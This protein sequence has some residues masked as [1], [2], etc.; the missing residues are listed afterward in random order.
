MTASHFNGSH[1]LLALVLGGCS[2]GAGGGSTGSPTASGT[3]EPT[4]AATGGAS[5]ADS[6]GGPTGDAPGSAST[7]EPTGE[8][9]ATTTSASG[10]GTTGEE[11]GMEPPVDTGPDPGDGFKPD[12]MPTGWK[13]ADKGGIDDPGGQ[14]PDGLGGVPKKLPQTG[15]A[16]CVK[17]TAGCTTE[18]AACPLYITINTNGAFFTRADDPATYGDFI[19]VELYVESDGDEIKHKLAELPRVIDHDYAGLDRDRV[20]AIGWSAGAGAVFRGL[21]HQSKK[22]DFSE[23]GTTSDIYAAVI[24]LGGCGCARDYVQL[25]GN[26]HV[27][28]FNGQNDPFNG[29]DACE[30]G[31]RERAAVNACSDLDATWQPLPADHPYVKNGDGSDNAE[32]LDFGSCAWGQVMGVRGRDEEHVTSFKKHF[33]PKISGYESTWNFLQSKRK[34]G[35]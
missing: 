5:A 7:D 20:Y 17:A 13:G 22:S 31:L 15:T 14:C 9:D 21:C 27:L 34:N 18:G 4:D 26:W 6:P 8:P 12:V 28:T 10:P 24:A 11:T 30:A 32:V 25:A 29:G 1:L 19:T 33:D 35:A 3:T 2:D 16:Y 23:L